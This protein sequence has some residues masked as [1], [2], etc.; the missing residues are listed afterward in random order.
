MHDGIQETLDCAVRALSMVD[1]V[2]AVVLGGS[3]AS[4]THTDDS[5]IDIG[6]YYDADSLDLAMLEK[7]AQT[8]DDGRREGLIAAPGEWGHW[9]NGG[10]WLQVGGRPVDFLLRDIARVQEVIHQC[11]VGIV[12][13]HYQTGHPHAFISAMY[14]GELA[15]AA[16]LWDRDGRIA[17]MQ[18]DA[19]QY[20]PKLKDALIRHFGFEMEFSLMF[21][22]K[23]W[24]KGDF[25]Y[26][27]AHLVRAASAL[28]QV[29]FALNETYCLNEK[30]AVQRID[31]LALRPADY[32]RRMDAVFSAGA[33]MERAWMLLRALVEETKSLLG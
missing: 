3:R 22:E 30:K 20:P 18:C 6:I 16:L 5:D 4:G 29:L 26:V 1:G 8:V 10:G 2:H 25:Y 33:D 23:N 12:S 9:V 7:A 31:G 21:V 13:S 28:N 15:V 19:R 27:T 11:K 24:A 17:A 14:M 32:K